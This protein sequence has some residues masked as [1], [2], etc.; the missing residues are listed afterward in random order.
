MSIDTENK[1][2]GVKFGL[3]KVGK[4]KETRWLHE[5]TIKAA[6]HK[7]K[8]VAHTGC[9]TTGLSHINQ[10]CITTQGIGGHRKQPCTGAE[11]G[12]YAH[13]QP[14]QGVLPICVISLV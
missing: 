1:K 4:H 7:M 2:A 12:V 6:G 9:V 3:V 13:W 14:D 11:S 10:N 8:A 5:S